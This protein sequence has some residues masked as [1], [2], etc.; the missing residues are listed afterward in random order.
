MGRER[1]HVRPHVAHHREG[2]MPMSLRRLSRLLALAAVVAC[3]L[4]PATGTRAAAAAPD[5]CAGAATA[6]NMVVRFYLA[7]DRRQFASAYRCLMA[8]EQAALRYP[9]FV[10][11]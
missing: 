1:Y 7:V 3:A 10:S 8:G 9:Y 2:H 11:G 6:T 5:A 4:G